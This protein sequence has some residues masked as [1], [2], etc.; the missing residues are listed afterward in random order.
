M[1][2]ELSAV[3]RR[4]LTRSANSQLVHNA[5]PRV[6]KREFLSVETINLW[7]QYKVSPWMQLVH[8]LNFESI[9]LSLEHVQFI[10]QFLGCFYKSF[11]C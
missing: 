8:P 3:M 11:A 7:L 4:K 2:H 6:L 10:C 1:G 5:I 9:Q